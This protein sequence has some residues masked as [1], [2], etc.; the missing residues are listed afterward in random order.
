MKAEGVDANRISVVRHG[1]PPTP[2]LP[3]R[4]MARRSLQL[5]D[6][7]VLTILGYISQ[8]KGHLL[9]IDALKNLPQEV[10]L[11]IAGG[12][13]FDDQSG[14]VAGVEEAIAKAGL[15]GRAR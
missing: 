10:V 13:H 11:M 12:R 7:F 3:E 15:S 14:Y 6:R 2:A 5:E 8:R 1:V 4:E 9:A